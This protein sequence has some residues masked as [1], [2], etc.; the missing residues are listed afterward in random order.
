[1]RLRGLRCAGRKLAQW[2]APGLGESLLAEDRLRR[3]GYLK[4]APVRCAWSEHLTGLRNREHL[5]WPVLM[6]E[7]WRET[8][9]IGGA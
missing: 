9:N 6:F 4:P 5:F 3:G 1:M 8:W 7:A 2:A